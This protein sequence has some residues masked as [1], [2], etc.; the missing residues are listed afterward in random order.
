MLERRRQ[1]R[2]CCCSSTMFLISPFPRLCLASCPGCP[3]ALL[4]R[5]VRALCSD[6]HI[7]SLSHSVC[8]FVVKL[9][10][11]P[12]ALC[13]S[14][15]HS[16]TGV[17]PWPYFTSWFFFSVGFFTMLASLPWIFVLPQIPA[18]LGTRPR[19]SLISTYVFK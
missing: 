6:V 14:V 18:Y 16:T 5:S 1:K 7:A 4:R 11:E 17:N 15:R 3:G 9:V 19:S 8:C 12:R 2:K 10:I 13:K